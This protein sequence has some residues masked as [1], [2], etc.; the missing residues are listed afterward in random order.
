MSYL[1]LIY[2]EA[3]LLI[4]AMKTEPHGIHSRNLTDGL[5]YYAMNKKDSLGSSIVNLS[6]RAIPT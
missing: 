3:N 6:I 1:P 4:R 5:S 2:F